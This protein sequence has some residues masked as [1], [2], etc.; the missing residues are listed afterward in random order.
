MFALVPFVKISATCTVFLASATFGRGFF[1]AT[2]TRT[3][4]SA[5][6]ARLFLLFH[7]ATG[8][9]FAAGSA[10]GAPGKRQAR[11][12]DETGKAVSRQ[13]LLDLLRVHHRPSYFVNKEVLPPRTGKTL[14]NL[15]SESHDILAQSREAAKGG[16]RPQKKL[17]AFASWRENKKNASS[18]RAQPILWLRLSPHV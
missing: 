16:L 6:F 10:G 8:T 1:G 7:G 4:T 9:G 2:C 5:T 18:R 11:P 13:N 3:A 14:T 17:C 15:D 12:G